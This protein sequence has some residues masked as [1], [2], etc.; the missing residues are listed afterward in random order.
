MRAPLR[1]LEEGG[2]RLLAVVALLRAASDTLY[3]IQV[4][5][6]IEQCVDVAGVFWAEI[7]A[8]AL[9]MRVDAQLY[10]VRDGVS[11]TG[12]GGGG[13]GQQQQQ[14]QQ[15][16]VRSDSKYVFDIAHEF[17]GVLLLINNHAYRYI[18]E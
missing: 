13:G 14:Q 1:A 2:E 9:N 8:N 6:E 3:P 4:N 11:V 12:Y 10:R 16:A 15:L 5:Y 7:V 17:Y 18:Y